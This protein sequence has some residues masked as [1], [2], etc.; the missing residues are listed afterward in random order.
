MEECNIVKDILIPIAASVIGGAFSFLGVYMTIKHEKNKDNEQKILAN[1]PLFYR[2]DPMQEY[3]YKE[4][5]DFILKTNNENKEGK[6]YGIF[7]NTDN[8]ILIIDGVI[9][10]GKTYKS[11]YGDVIDKN[12]IFNLYVYI[13]EKLGQKNEIIFVVKDILGNK[14]KYSLEIKNDKKSSEI[15]GFKEI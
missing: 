11:L 14:Y 5:V 13:D 4:S 8:A 2:I 6:I 9:V 1:K 15:I 12:Q 10:N 7:K 3:P